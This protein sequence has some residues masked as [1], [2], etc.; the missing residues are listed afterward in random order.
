LVEDENPEPKVDTGKKSAMDV[1]A[2]EYK[3][4]QAKETVKK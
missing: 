3:A 1:Y 2:E 4:R